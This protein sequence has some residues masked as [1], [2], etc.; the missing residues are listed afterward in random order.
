[1]KITSKILSIPPYLSTTWK[2]I[3]SLHVRT[4]GQH[5]TLL[6]LLQNR[7]QVEV[8]GLT[9]EA[10][11]E[12]FAAHS[13]SADEERAVQLPLD[14]P[15]SFSL[16]INSEGT[17]HA[18][19]SSFQ[20]NPEQTNLPPLQPEILQKIATV[21][22]AFGVED[23]SFL[24]KPEE[25]CNCMYCQL[26]RTFK[27]EKLQEEQI[28]EITQ[29]DLRFRDWEIVQT[30][31]KLYSVTNPLDQNEQY[32]VFL[33]EPLGCTCGYKNCEHIRSVLNS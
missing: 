23:L 11:D 14:S 15:F 29:E 21:A 10:I 27:D 17:L 33:G 30:G 1:M 2:N 9:K 8:P 13:R 26:C 28:E 5:F 25:N 3:S 6:V 12:I 22:R 7:V 32:N 24:S 18:L 20:H 16:P 4:E 31:E 19:S